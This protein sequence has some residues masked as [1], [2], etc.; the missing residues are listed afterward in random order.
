MGE[1]QV[2]RTAYFRSSGIRSFTSTPGRWLLASLGVGHDAG[3]EGPQGDGD[4]PAGIA[5]RLRHA[6]LPDEVRRVGEDE[7]PPGRRVEVAHHARLALAAAEPERARLA[8]GDRHDGGAF[9]HV[10]GGIVVLADVV[11]RP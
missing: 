6:V 7:D 11:A 9:L 2:P 4:A 3:G 8:E 5:G 1:S 10:L